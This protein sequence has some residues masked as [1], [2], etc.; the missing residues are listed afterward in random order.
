M[1]P[2]K[3]AVSSIAVD[4]YIK[5][6]EYTVDNQYDLLVTDYLSKY[7]ETKAHRARPWSVL[8]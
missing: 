4:I 2:L 5:V 1:N 7:A 6:A 3:E 8:A